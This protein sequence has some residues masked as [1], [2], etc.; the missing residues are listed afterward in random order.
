[1]HNEIAPGDRRFSVRK[2]HEGDARA[3]LSCLAA[4]FA[5][6]RSRYTPDAYADTVLLAPGAIE[7]RLREMSLL[8]AEV[9]GKVVGT[10]GSQQVGD[11]GHLR[12]MAVLPEW[13]GT[14]VASSLLQAAEAELRRA[15]CKRITLDTTE[16]LR[17]AIR[18]YECNGYCA[19]SRV[20]D[21]FGMS[22]YEYAKSL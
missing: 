4:A 19:T 14:S 22:L 1:M 16:P 7:R 5:P 20:S 10:I 8:V 6:Y 17:R 12:G 9:D 3:I 2:A 11:E 15:G 13:H 21:F 18:F